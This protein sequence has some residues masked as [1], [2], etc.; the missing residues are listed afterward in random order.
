MRVVRK[1]IF[2]PGALGAAAFWHPVGNRLPVEWRKSLSPWVASL[3]C[4][5]R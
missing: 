1:L 5:L 3:R 4:V 2:L